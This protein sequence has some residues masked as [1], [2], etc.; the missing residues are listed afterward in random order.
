LGLAQT[1]KK[2]GSA[3]KMKKNLLIA[4]LLL[5]LISCSS[6]TDAVAERNSLST[7]SQMSVQE[8][9]ILQTSDESFYL[10]DVREEWEREIA[11]I[12]DSRILNEKTVKFIGDLERDSL[13]VFQCRTGSRSQSAAEY[14]QKQGFTRVF[15]LAGGID[16]WSL[17]IDP[18]IVRYSKQDRKSA[19]K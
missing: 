3:G 11:Q 9:K 18:E 15:N 13:M 4:I 1:E 10:F 14:F 2:K 16:A 6:E 12:A 17:E 7:V 8:L 19:V 5:S